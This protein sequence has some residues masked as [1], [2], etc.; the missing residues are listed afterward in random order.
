MA[1]ISPISEKT[2]LVSTNILIN[3][4]PIS[5]LYQVISIAVEKEINRIPYAR[6]EILD[7]DP[8]KE[9]F[10]IS[11]SKDFVPG[12]EITIK[13][14]YHSKNDVIFRGLVIKHGIRI[15]KG[16]SPSLI[17]ECRD[18]AIAMTI[19][20]KSVSYS[21]VS[22]SDVFSQIAGS[23]SGLSTDIDSTK[24]Q[25]KELL[26]YYSTDWDFVISRAD[27]NGLVVLVDDGKVS[28]KKPDTGSSPVLN[29]SYGDTILSME[30]EID[31]RTQFKSVQCNSWDH[32]SQAIVEADSEAPSLTTPGNLKR[33]DLA[34][35]A[36]PAVYKLHTTAPL[37][38][39][40]LQSWANALMTKS[41]LSMVSGT[42]SFQGNGTVKPGVM[43]S[44]SGIGARFNGNIYVSGVAHTIEKG[45]W[46][47]KVAYGDTSKWF[48]ESQENIMSAPAAGLLPAIQGLHNGVV[49]KID[50][51][52]DGEYRVQ[53]KIPVI[54]ETEG[55]WARLSNLYATADAGTVFYPEINDEVIVG[56]LNDDPSFPVILGSM[57][58]SSKAP[59]YKPDSTNTN[60]AIV[61]KSKLQIVFDDV[62]KVTQI[63]TPA[64]NSIVLSDDD[65]SIT[66]TDQNNNSIKLS[67]D[68][69]L[70]KSASSIEIKASQDITM[71]AGG[72]IKI[73]STGDTTISGNN[74]SANAKM[75]ATV[76]GMSAAQLTATGQVTVKGAVVMIN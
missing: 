18:K 12:N 40:G 32:K 71:E 17:V 9:N 38:K 19:G 70:I 56:F 36:G 4:S 33:A 58:S 10:E 1:T 66:I 27:I 57:Y 50:E 72:N 42:L 44:I 65:T 34:S 5:D 64:K 45:N 41:V 31:A 14:G 68:G 48:S 28:I 7:G 29:L 73:T 20:R 74:V 26:Q 62:K 63:L 54:S 39:N 11:S 49:M 24:V 3:G 25:I 22:D 23:Y 60:K 21:D 75:K 8:A 67:S 13:A 61:T 6:I 46:I 47:T 59:H 16:R 51:D 37:E 2:D 15:R 30:S 69:I 52:P 53:I 43:L 76:S 55:V 35:V